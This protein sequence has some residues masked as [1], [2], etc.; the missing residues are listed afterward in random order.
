MAN[1]KNQAKRKRDLAKQGKRPAKGRARAQRKAGARGASAPAAASRAAPS[2]A[3]A[4]PMTVA[5]SAF[6]RRMNIGS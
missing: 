5:A 2:V 4:K 6:I 3:K 1:S